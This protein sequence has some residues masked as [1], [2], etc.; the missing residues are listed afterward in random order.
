MRVSMHSLL[1]ECPVSAT[2]TIFLP[3]ERRLQTMWMRRPLD[4]AATL[5]CR[6][7]SGVVFF[8]RKTNGNFPDSLV[9]L[10]I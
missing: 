1:N 9:F 6:K 8:M 10:N 7:I 4:F 5:V 2:Q 3:V